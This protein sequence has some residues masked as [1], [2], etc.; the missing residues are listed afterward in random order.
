MPSTIEYQEFDKFYRDSNI[1]IDERI[2]DFFDSLED[3]LKTWTDGWIDK[4]NHRKIGHKVDG[5]VIAILDNR[6]MGICYFWNLK[7]YYACGIVVKKEYQ[8]KDIGKALLRTGMEW[9]KKKGVKRI[10]SSVLVNN[11]SSI[12]SF[13]KTDWIFSITMGC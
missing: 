8:N 12:A 1:I 4:D 3:E 7:Y 13:I 10:V 9:C 5:G 2:Q 6:V 11:Y